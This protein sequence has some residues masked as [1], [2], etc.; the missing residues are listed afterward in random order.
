M[1]D[2]HEPS[3]PASVAR[4][5]LLRGA[6]GLVL[7]G[8]LVA[9]GATAAQAATSQNGWSAG[10]SSQI[11]ISGLTVSAASFPAGVRSGQVH[12]ILGYVARRFNS[13]VEALVSG[14]C[15]GHNYRAISGST[16]LSNHASGTAIDVNAPRHPLGA[17]GT[18]SSTQRTR[19]HAILAY[20]DGVVR[21]GGD[22][23]GRKDEMH[24]EIN[25]RPG[26]PRLAALVTKIGGGGGGGSTTVVWT[27]VQRGASGFRVVAIQHLLR[28]R[29]YSLT[30]DGSFGPTTESKVIA[31]Q[32]SRGLVGDGV[33][34]PK[35]WSALVVTCERGAAGQAVVAIQKTLTHRGYS[36][37]ADGSFG[38]ATESKVVAFQTSRGL[39]GDGIV[40]PKTWAKLTA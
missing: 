15:W 17:T 34:G 14:W 35:T 2:T 13:E 22:Y 29:G 33:V 39:V 24:F 27:T 8:G 7:A 1:C 36:L 3:A 19:I 37:A 26:D 11:P 32:T 20:C 12:T 38:P 4:R 9:S 21:W 18:F 10:S 40:G 31:F 16:T 25:V 28:H 23:S 30:V 6:G 5:T